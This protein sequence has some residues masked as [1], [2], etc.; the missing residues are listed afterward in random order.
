MLNEVPASAPT[1]DLLTLLGLPGVGPKGAI[2]LAEGD[3]SDLRAGEE[4][5]RSREQAESI[6]AD[7]ATLGVGIVGWFDNGFP[8]R[9]RTIPQVPAVLYFRGDLLAAHRPG[10]AAVVGTREPSDWGIRATR[11]ITGKL[12]REGWCIV[13]GLALGVDTAAH[14]TALETGAATVAVLG[15]GLA[16]VYPP[17]NRD[18]AREIVDA[19]GLLLAEVSPRMKVEPRALVQRDRLQSGLSAFTLVIQGS[20]KSGAMHTARYAHEQD[21]PLFCATVMRETEKPGQQ[22][23]GTQVL[24]EEAGRRLPELLPSWRRVSVSRLGTE[25][26]ARP[27]DEVALSKLDEIHAAGGPPRLF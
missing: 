20:R 13:S 8:E 11:A 4:W 12:A 24:L 16:T 23:E 3:M 14:Q 15:N 17:A 25:P 22:D 1:L 6:A 21:R 10:S 9:L 18:L 26:V 27:F 19:G 2:R 7:C 5:A